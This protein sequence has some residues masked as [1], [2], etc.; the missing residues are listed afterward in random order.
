MELYALIERYSS[1]FFTHKL[2]VRLDTNGEL[3][4]KWIRKR[5]MFGICLG[6]FAILVTYFIPVIGILLSFIFFSQKN[7]DIIFLVDDFNA[8]IT[9]VTKDKF[10]RR[11]PNWLV[12][13]SRRQNGKG[14]LIKM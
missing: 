11:N 10:S 12:K 2:Y 5:Y 7:I 3:I 1:R 6:V 8:D 13:T 9:I 14:T 4:Q